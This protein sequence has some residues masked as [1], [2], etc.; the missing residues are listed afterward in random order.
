MTDQPQTVTV[1]LGDVELTRE[2]FSILSHA[3]KLP[4]AQRRRRSAADGDARLLEAGHRSA[5]K[6]HGRREDGELR[7]A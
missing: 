1:Q 2:Q 5:G 4:G 6:Q 3:L 7:A